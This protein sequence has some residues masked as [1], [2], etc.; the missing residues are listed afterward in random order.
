M[1]SWRHRVGS[2]ILASHRMTLVRHGH[3]GHFGAHPMARRVVICT[4]IGCRGRRDSDC[5]SRH[6]R[7]QPKLERAHGV[8]AGAPSSRDSGSLAVRKQVRSR[9]G[10]R[11][12]AQSRKTCNR[13]G[14]GPARAERSALE[15]RRTDGGAG[16]PGRL[17]SRQCRGCRMPSAPTPTIATH[18][19]P[20]RQTVTTASVLPGMS[21]WVWLPPDFDARARTVI[22]TRKSA[23]T[24]STVRP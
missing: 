6:K 12:T 8:H 3:T 15:A 21:P 14:G 16:T 10:A 24:Q 17:Q 23:A 5:E 9:A 1:A 18:A 20:N 19:P 22:P 13:G 7:W 4:R 11:R 2:R